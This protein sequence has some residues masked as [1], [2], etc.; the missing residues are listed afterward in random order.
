[1]DSEHGERSAVNS[2]TKFPKKLVGFST[3]Y[4]ERGAGASPRGNPRP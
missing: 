2:R 4:R 1:M 3:S